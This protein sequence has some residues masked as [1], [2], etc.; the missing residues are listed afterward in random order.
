MTALLDRQY[1]SQYA[2]PTFAVQIFRIGEPGN[3]DGPV[4]V[5]LTLDG[6][7]PTVVTGWPK[8]ADNPNVGL[9]E[10][11]L[12]PADTSVPGFYTL[13]FDAVVNTVAQATSYPIQ[14]GESAPAYDALSQPWKNVVES[15]WAMF[16][17]LFDSP[18]GGPNLQV[19]FQSNFGRNRIAQLLG[20]ALQRLNSAASPHQSFAY[21][22]T[23]FPF[24]TWG[25]LL[26]KSLYIEVIRHL[27]R[28]YVEIP[29]PQL[30]TNVSRLE[31]RDYLDRWGVILQ[32][33]QADFERDLSRFRQAMMGL[34]N[35]HVLVSGGAFGNIGP[36]ALPGGLG[37]AAARG[38]FLF[39]RAF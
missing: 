36:V 13:T 22:G 4:E 23:D 10:I 29:E 32:E 37:Q 34:G 1:I 11:S 5:T 19:Y 12:T 24:D 16:A 28:S 3:A 26:A 27:R 14:I 20:P 38:Y 30:A 21:G 31:R 9:Y 8:T 15:V 2:Q 6:P 7:S 33:E 35:F 25:G 18:Y 17:D 39:T